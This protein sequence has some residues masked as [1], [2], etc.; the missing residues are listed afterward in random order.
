MSDGEY[1]V[2]DWGDGDDNGDDQWG[3]ANS[4]GGD[5]NDDKIEIENNFY[6]AEGMLKDNPTEA[7]ERFE[8]VVMMEEQRDESEYSFN[9]HKYIVILAAQLGQYDKMIKS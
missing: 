9:S 8:T 4:G 7:L 6:E 1:D 3:D 2:E 5:V